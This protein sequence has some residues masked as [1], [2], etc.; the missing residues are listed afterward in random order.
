MAQRFLLVRGALVHAPRF[1]D[2]K[3]IEDAAVLVDTST[4]A[5]LEVAAGEQEATL[6]AKNGAAATRQLRLISTQFLAP[7]LIDM[8]IHAPQVKTYATSL[9][10]AHVQ[11]A[12]DSKH[13][14]CSFHR[15]STSAPTCPLLLLLQ[16][17]TSS[18]ALRLGYR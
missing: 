16:R 18:P 17:S 11:C 1:E 8:H 6:L 7:G 3:A 4:G 12:C 10:L 13:L 14:Y 5:I 2:L 9:H 15:R